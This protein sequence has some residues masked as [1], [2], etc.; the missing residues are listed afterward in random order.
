MKKQR[1]N[2]SEVAEILIEEI[3]QFKASVEEIKKTKVKLDPENV[4]EIKRLV[5]QQAEREKK[6]DSKNEAFL[7]DLTAL[8]KKK[9]SRIPNSLAYALIG[10][11]LALIGFSAYSWNKFDE[12]RLLKEK[13]QY[14]ESKEG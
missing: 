6:I 9:Q 2:V 10:L 3:D 7:A 12:L 5:Q 13:V 4:E 8:T 11:I 1:Y 14:Y